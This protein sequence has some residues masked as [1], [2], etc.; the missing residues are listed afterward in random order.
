MQGCVAFVELVIPQCE[1]IEADGVQERGIGFAQFARAVEVQC[2]GERI[3][4]MQLE[5]IILASR[6]L[7]KSRRNARETRSID[8]DRNPF[9]RRI[10]QLQQPAPAVEVGM[11]VVDV[12]NGEIKR[13]LWLMIAMAAACRK[14]A[15]HQQRKGQ[16]ECKWRLIH[17]IFVSGG[18]TARK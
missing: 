2:A 17:A 12:Q 6:Q 7:G 5:H 16:G 14:Q 13:S 3:A 8:R 9:T 4:R 15:G 18:H 10:A 11:R 1:G